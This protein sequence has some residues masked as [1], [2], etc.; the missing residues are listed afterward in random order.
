MIKNNHLYLSASILFCMLVFLLPISVAGVSIVSAILIALAVYYV[1]VNPKSVNWKL[2]LIFGLYYSFTL[3]SIFYSENTSVAFQKALLK[4][5]ILF[6]PLFIGIIKNQNKYWQLAFEQVFIWMAVFIAFFSTI[7]YYSNKEALDFLVLQNKPIP[8]MSHIYHIEFSILLALAILV[9]VYRLLYFYWA[10]SLFQYLY[11]VAGIIGTYC[12][13]VMS[14]RTGMLC[15]YTGVFVL[16]IYNIIQTKKY[17]IL[18]AGIALMG[19]VLAAGYQFSESFRNRITLTLDDINVLQTERDR[20]WHSV[21]M[22]VDAFNNGVTVFKENPWFGVGVGD[23]DSAV[24]L[25]FIQ[26]DSKLQ[27]VNRKKPHHQFLENALQSGVFSPVLLLT[28]LLIPF[29]VKKYRNPLSVTL[30]IV[31]FTAMQFESILERQ[32]TVVVFV[33]LY[34]YV[35]SLGRD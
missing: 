29:I 4:L 1:V 20:N 18:I 34:A 15:L 12:L 5:P 2:M 30:M 16:L 26:Q 35:L 6:V 24:Q 32:A 25:S 14:V 10:G 23:V 33:L 27:L 9:C 21:S 11:L 31:F 8:V 17:W 19:T 7:N 3:L 22:R 13:H 28:I